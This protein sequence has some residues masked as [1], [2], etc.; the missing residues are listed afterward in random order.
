M[1]VMK[2]EELRTKSWFNR[3]GEEVRN[4]GNNEQ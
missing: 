1:M 2:K 4:N 3:G